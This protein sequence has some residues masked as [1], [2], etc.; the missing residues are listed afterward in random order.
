MITCVYKWPSLIWLNA[1]EFTGHHVSAVVLTF[2]EVDADPLAAPLAGEVGEWG[3][4]QTLPEEGALATALG[5]GTGAG[6]E[7]AAWG[8]GGAGGCPDLQTT[9]TTTTPCTGVPRLPRQRP[10]DGLDFDGRRGVFGSGGSVA[11]GVGGGAVRGGGEEGANKTPLI[12][13]T[14]AN[15]KHL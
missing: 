3:E 10:Q 1:E 4:A 15:G 8:V 12:V 11:G 6:G 7:T 2:L 14:V 13:L 5:A 9:T